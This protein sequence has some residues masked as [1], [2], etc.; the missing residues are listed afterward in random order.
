MGENY[1]Y[2]K[3]GWKPDKR[4]R[5]LIFE[6]TDGDGQHDKRTVF[7]EDIT[8]VSG[9][10]VGYGGVWVGSPPNLLF[11]PDKDGDDVPDG[12]AEIVL[13][14]WGRRIN[15]RHL[16]RLPG[17][18]TAGCT[19]VTACSRIPKSASPARPQRTACRSTPAFGD[20]TR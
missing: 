9:L 1:T 3:V 13:D 8:Y 17:G 4:D 14:G 20:I 19:A 16:T 11:I 6:D 18:R 5:I 12:K 10:E 2:T 15:T 7:T